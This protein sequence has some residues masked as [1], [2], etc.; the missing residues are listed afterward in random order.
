MYA[1]KTFMGD[2]VEYFARVVDTYECNFTSDIDDA[3]LFDTEMIAVHY[4]LVFQSQFGIDCEV[5]KVEK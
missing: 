3:M 4:S 1:L 2:D 5:V